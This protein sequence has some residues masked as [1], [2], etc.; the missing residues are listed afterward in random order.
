MFLFYLVVKKG[1]TE[2]LK[3]KKI[4]FFIFFIRLRCGF[5]MVLKKIARYS[6]R[7]TAYRHVLTA[8]TDR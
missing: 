8:Q 5:P 4:E 6:V 1:V 7:K 3:N 2:S